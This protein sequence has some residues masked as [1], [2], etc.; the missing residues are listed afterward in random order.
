LAAGFAMVGCGVSDLREFVVGVLRQASGVARRHFGRA[1]ATV[2][3]HDRNQ[4]LT[5]ADLEIAGLVAGA[6]DGR[7]SDHNR[8]DE[9]LGPVDR[10]SAHTWVVDPIDGTSN[11][12]VGIPLYGVMIG[13]LDGG[14]PRACGIALPEFDAFYY[15]ERGAGAWCNG[16]RLSV[17]EY[18]IGD[19]LVAYGIDGHADDARRTRH[20]C[21]TLAEIAV[22]VRNVRSSNSAYDAVMLAE[23]RYAAWMVQTSRIWDSVAP[24][25]L[26]EEA[27]GRFTR[28]DGGE[29]SY[30][31]PLSR[32]S[33][34][35]TICAAAP[36]V[37]GELQAIIGAGRGRSG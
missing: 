31:R 15:A 17:K 21:M 2:K 27:G 35:F 11:F 10:G 9:E 25:L 29:V 7:F 1:E 28:F 20:E 4:V 34:N 16:R 26:I 5:E 23:G 24:Q 14:R 33:D 19:A 12:T 3:T 36:G 13:L 30:D 18:A 37:H 32:V 6:I 22:A 8:I